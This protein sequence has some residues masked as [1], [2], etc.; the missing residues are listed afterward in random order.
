M[1]SQGELFDEIGYWSELKLDI[2]REYAAAY[3]RILNAQKNPSFQHVYIDAFAGLGIHISKT[4][5]KFIQGSPLNA[6]LIDPPFYEYHLIDLDGKKTT[7]LNE[8]TQ[9]DKRVFVYNGDCNRILLEK[10]FPQVKWSD[11]KR[12]LCLLDPYGLQLNWEVVETAGQMKTIDMFLNFPVMDMNRNVLWHNPE[13]VAAKNI[14]RMT[15]FWGDLSW[16]D[17]AYKPVKTL[18][19]DWDQKTGNE[20]IVTAFCERLMKVAGFNHVPEPLP[21]R[22]SKGAVIYYLF[23]ASQKPTAEYIIT[24]IFNKYKKRGAG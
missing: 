4:T 23:F 15:A 18:F 22:N 21:M 13:G 1:T 3:S 16:R 19:G 17:I 8:L 12:G 9:D 14:D 6:L 10:V 11:Y 7:H 20:E 24:N 2:V 5:G